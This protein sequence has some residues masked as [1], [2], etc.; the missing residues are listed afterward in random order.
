MQVLIKRLRV[1]F[2]PVSIS[3]PA[4]RPCGYEVRGARRWIVQETPLPC[5]IGPDNEDVAAH[6][7]ALSD[8]SGLVPVEIPCAEMAAKDLDPA[9]VYDAALAAFPGRA[10][11]Q[12]FAIRDGRGGLAA[13]YV[14]PEGNPDIIAA[15][16]DR[17]QAAQWA[18]AY[19]DEIGVCKGAD[20][21]ARMWRECVA[22]ALAD[23]AVMGPL[24]DPTDTMAL[25]HVQRAFTQAD[26]VKSAQAALALLPSAK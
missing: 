2:S 16:V 15:G 1:S 12:F 6:F 3:V 5:G 22:K 26:Y 14:D 7:A 24:F 4:L 17:A 13:L 25:A 11:A 10:D 19:A 18:K 8:L 21:G 9:I 23:P 20:S